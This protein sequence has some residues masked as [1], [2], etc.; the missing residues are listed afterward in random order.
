MAEVHTLTTGEVRALDYAAHDLSKVDQDYSRWEQLQFYWQTQQ[1]L[2]IAAAYRGIAEDL[3]WFVGQP[4]DLS[5]RTRL[6]IEEAQKYLHA[7]MSEAELAEFYGA[8][9]DTD[10]FNAA[11]G[12]ST[13]ILDSLPRYN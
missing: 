7:T 1:L 9:N 12:E 2:V 5:L 6:H 3:R 8:A 10:D 13:R 4:I 11:T